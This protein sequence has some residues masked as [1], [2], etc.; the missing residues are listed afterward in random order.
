MVLT[1]KSL[2]D[3]YGSTL[4]TPPYSACTSAY[5]LHAA[6]TRDLGIDV[7]YATVRYWYDKYRFHGELSAR[8]AAE[9]NDKYG[10]ILQALS[11]DNS[12]AYKLCKALRERTPP[13]YLT[14]RVSKQWLFACRGYMDRIENAGHL[15]T[16]YGDRIR[17]HLANHSLDALGIQIEKFDPSAHAPPQKVICNSSKFKIFSKIGAWAALSGAFVAKFGIL[18]KF[19]VFWS[20]KCFKGWNLSNFMSFL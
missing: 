15:E 6:I 19:Y 10:E 11:V 7:T 18:V 1:T 17:S 13:V 5:L 3:G 12:T 20:H 14:D 16:Q 4:R 8:S 2:E 9:A